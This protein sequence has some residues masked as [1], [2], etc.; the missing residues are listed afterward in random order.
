MPDIISSLVP[1][2][3]LFILGVFLRKLNFTTVEQGAFL[4]KLV[5][6]VG[7]PALIVV[8]IAKVE[9]TPEK[10]YLPLIS[11]LVILSCMAAALLYFRLRDIPAQTR[12]AILISTMIMNGVFMFAIILGGFGEA[13]FADAVLFDFGNAI[14][15]STITYLMAFR[16]S[17]EHHASVLSRLSKSTLFWAV[18]V[19]LGLNLLA[20]PLPAVIQGFL[21][22]IGNITVPLI[23]IGLGILFRP[24]AEHLELLA[25]TLFIRMAIGMA[26]GTLLAIVLGLEG[27]T[28]I[29]VS[30]CA[31][32]PIGFN[33]LS[34]ASV[35]KLDVEFT[36]SAISS[37]VIV[38]M[39]LIPIYIFLYEV[40][41]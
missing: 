5:T 36:S 14:M 16:Y 28:F 23:L 3:L 29:V 27:T 6:F 18:V 33:A 39:V 22:P 26:V 12:G 35:A 30:L 1:L 10:I 24:R 40:L 17:H 38:G 19:G 7:L 8:A 11:V 21:V 25:P 20:I 37:S 9:L 13:A 4:L 34:F 31:G 32:A 41:A 15:V 2:F